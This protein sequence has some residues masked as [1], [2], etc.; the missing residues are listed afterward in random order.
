MRDVRSFGVRTFGVWTF[1]VWTFGVWTSG[2][3][4]FGVRSF[5]VRTFRMPLRV[6]S[7]GSRLRP[8][9]RGELS[10]GLG[11]ERRRMGAEANRG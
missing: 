2:V 5:G 11:S 10:R 9:V 6:Q 8:V 3:R 1:G 4:S 7:L